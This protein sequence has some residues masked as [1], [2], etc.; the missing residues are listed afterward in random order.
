MSDNKTFI[1]EEIDLIFTTKMMKRNSSSISDY[2]TNII[3]YRKCLYC[4][5]KT[6]QQQCRKFNN[7]IH[8]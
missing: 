7:K 3:N 2:K 8:K 6:R 5:L 1:N 4:M